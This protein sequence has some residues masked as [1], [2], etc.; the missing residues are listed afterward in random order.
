M[1]EWVSI[2][3]LNHLN[4]FFP[5]SC[6]TWCA[7]AH[8][9][10]CIVATL[11]FYVCLHTLGVI[12]C[13][14]RYTADTALKYKTIY[15]R[16]YLRPT[17][18]STFCTM[19]CCVGGRFHKER[20]NKWLLFKCGNNGRLFKL[21]SRQICL[22]TYRHHMIHIR[23]EVVYGIH[24]CCVCSNRTSWSRIVTNGPRSI[25]WNAFNWIF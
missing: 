15:W 16:N 13:V 22:P 12:N 11:L 5:W 2:K 1:A 23:I 18:R 14:E 19:Q 21:Y 3:K 25:M 20:S 4:C 24:D 7:R 10:I 9:G 6:T 8:I 17:R